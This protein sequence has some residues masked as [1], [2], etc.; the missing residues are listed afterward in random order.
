MHK[1]KRILMLIF[2]VSSIITSAKADIVNFLTD[3]N[4]GFENGGQALY[5]Q[6]DTW[7]VTQ[8]KAAPSGNYSLKYESDVAVT[9]QNKVNGGSNGSTI[10]LPAGTYKFKVKVW[11]QSAA[12]ISGFTFVLKEPFT[13]FNYSFNGIEREQWVELE[14]EQTFNTE[15]IDSE[16][17]FKIESS[18]GGKGVFYIDD[19]QIWGEAIIPPVEVPYSS[20]IETVESNN[21]SLPA[22][23]YNMH[24]KVWVEESTSISSFYTQL[25][26]PFV[27]LKWDIAAV[28]KG[29]WVE[30]KQEM[31]LSSDC[32]NTSFVLQVA[33]NPDYGGG[34][35]TFYIDDIVFIKK[36]DTGV[37]DETKFS[38]RVFPNPA[39][40]LL[41][42][43]S[44]I[45]ADYILYNVSGRIVKK[46]SLKTQSI[47]IPVSDISKGMY[48]LQIKTQKDIVVESVI[49]K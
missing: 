36:D 45:P 29:E 44:E 12:E 18:H 23:D 27:S 43:E 16:C 32:E 17:L 26:E 1:Y 14:I 24:L 7:S 19:F 13:T 5:F 9:S 21:I 41:Q 34:I 6:H 33:N 49:I 39:S 25:K 11:L 40:Q 8:E 31:S 35:G 10:S 37:D 46:S 47:T 4:Y 30:L 22:A 2:A 28:A 3:D 48:L 42:I 20:I 38:Y 15:V